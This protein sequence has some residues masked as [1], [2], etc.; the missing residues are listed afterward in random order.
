MYKMSSEIKEDLVIPPEKY[1]LK[2]THFFAQSSESHYL[3][4]QNGTADTEIVYFVSLAVF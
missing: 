4:M 1:I 3:I 2:F